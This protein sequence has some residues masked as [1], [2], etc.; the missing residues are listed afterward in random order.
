[1]NASIG[2]DVAQ[3]GL[4]SELLPYTA[5][6]PLLYSE[7]VKADGEFLNGNKMSYKIRHGVGVQ[8]AI[9]VNYNQDLTTKV[10][11]ILRV[12]MLNS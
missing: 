4:G 8:F 3:W 5:M 6:R 11:D 7:K 12:E 9:T 10:N 1:M 2:G